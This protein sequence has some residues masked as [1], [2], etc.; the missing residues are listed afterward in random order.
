MKEL[1][2]S[3]FS[4]ISDESWLNF[5]SINPILH[6]EINE[7]LKV[8]A[9]PAMYYENNMI[10]PIPYRL[11]Y[12][13][14]CKLKYPK[15]MDTELCCVIEKVLLTR[16][17]NGFIRA[18]AVMYLLQKNILESHSFVAPYLIRLLG[19][20]VKEIWQV[21]YE[22]K[23][24]FQVNSVQEFVLSNPKFLQITSDRTITYTNEYYRN[25]YKHYKDAE[26]YK[27][28]Q[29]LKVMI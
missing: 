8:Q 13:V 10:Y 18:D 27:M 19:E 29:Y 28:I 4:I 21:I 25:D 5:L 3:L 9:Y 23:E 2:K 20:Y 17:H 26:G 12:D 14:S 16:H 6:R 7:D 22:S 15:S 24:L 11:F 1:D